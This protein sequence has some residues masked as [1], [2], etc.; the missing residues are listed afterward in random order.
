MSQRAAVLSS[1]RRLYRARAA[2]FGGDVRAMGESRQAVRAQ[3]LQHGAQEI[4]DLQHFQGLLGMVDDAVDML[5]HGIVR[6]DLNPKTG[7]L[8]CVE[9]IALLLPPRSQAH[10]LYL[11]DWLVLDIRQATKR[12]SFLPCSVLR[13]SAM[14][15]SCCSTFHSHSS[16]NTCWCIR[17]AF[18]STHI[19][20]H[21]CMFIR[22][23]IDDA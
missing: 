20:M 10:S 2:L 17:V 19:V 11:L 4:A 5:R 7:P 14:L 18:I 16:P 12:S 8:R 15:S 21:F 9:R 3:Y 6:G 22:V 13:K 1:Y 23:V